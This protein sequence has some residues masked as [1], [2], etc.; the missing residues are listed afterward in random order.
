[1]NAGSALFPWSI[2]Y[3]C[4]SLSLCW[5]GQQSR[6]LITLIKKLEKNLKDSSHLD[7]MFK[8]IEFPAGVP[9]LATGLTHV[10]R[11][12]LALGKNYLTKKKNSEKYQIYDVP[13]R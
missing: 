6:L 9:D 5:S 2:V 8:T 10:D 3:V 13:S 7:A 11:D 1:M 4:T 12:A